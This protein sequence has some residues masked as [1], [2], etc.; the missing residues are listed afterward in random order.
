M[1][2]AWFLD[3]TY[4]IRGYLVVIASYQCN[5]SESLVNNILLYFR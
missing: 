1:R 4:V 5:N 3:N 2:R